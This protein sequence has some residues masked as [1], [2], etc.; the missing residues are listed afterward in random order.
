MYDIAT[1][2]FSALISLTIRKPP[3]VLWKTKGWRKPKAFKSHRSGEKQ[4]KNNRHTNE[5]IITTTKMAAAAAATTTKQKSK[6]DKST[7]TNNNDLPPPPPLPSPNK[8]KTGEDKLCD[9]WWTPWKA[10]RRQRIDCS[11]FVRQQSS[12]ISP[13][14]RSSVRAVCL[15]PCYKLS[16]G[17]VLPM[18][19]SPS[20]SAR[21]NPACSPCMKGAWLRAVGLVIVFL[22]CWPWQ[23]PATVTQ[24]WPA[25]SA[26]PGPPGHS[27]LV[28]RPRT[29]QRSVVCS[30]VAWKARKLERF[31]EIVL[32]QLTV[33]NLTS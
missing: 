19:S 6:Q 21:W 26:R 15:S 23:W 29:P 12:L 27:S 7:T 18:P 17:R 10:G 32:V 24:V 3:P 22:L 16:A 13:P 8:T 33:T 11:V 25:V 5:Q 30:I 14:P 28:P 31:R 1:I 9:V 20:S 2:S 4:N